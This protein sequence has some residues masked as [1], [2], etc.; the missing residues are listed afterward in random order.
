MRLRNGSVVLTRYTG[1]AKYCQCNPGLI[2]KLGT[3]RFLPAVNTWEGKEEG[4]GNENECWQS[5]YGVAM[6][7]SIW[8]SEQK[9]WCPR[10]AGHDNL[11]LMKFSIQQLPFLCFLANRNS[12][13]MQALGVTSPKERENITTIETLADFSGESTGC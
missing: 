1:Q 10:K 13:R 7:L 4:R 3:E 6:C 8:L 2:L 11:F 9:L 5:L 12:D